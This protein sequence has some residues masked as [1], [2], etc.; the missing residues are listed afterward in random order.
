MHFDDDIHLAYSTNIH[1]GN[2][3]EE[4]FASLQNDTLRVMKKVGAGDADKPFGIGLRLSN[5]A[6]LELSDRERLT[7]FRHWLDANHGYVFTINGFPY[8]QFHGTRVKEQVYVPDW[9]SGERLEY[10]NRLFTLLA[11]LLPPGGEGSVSTLPGSFKPFITDPSQVGT[12]KR[13]L[14]ECARHI[15]SLSEAKG[16][17][18]H[19]GLEPEP[20]GYLETT[21]ETI[22]FFRDLSE[23]SPDPDMIRRRIGVN[24]DTCHMAI[25]FET[26][27]ASLARLAENRIRISK[28]HLSSALRVVPTEEV[29][30]GLGDFIDPVYLHQVVSRNSAGVMARWMDLDQALEAEPDQSGADSEWR[31]HFHVPLYA[32]PDG[33]MDTTIDHLEAALDYLSGRRDLCRHYEFE[34][35][36][37]EV[38]PARMRSD[39]VVDQ[40]VAE[41]EWCLKAFASRGIRWRAEN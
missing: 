5:Q 14:I 29:R 6:S 26:A 13:N 35:Y 41:Y 17:D 25:Q 16:L 24:Y 12:I 4:T 11:E 23:G 27:A 10:T 7:E 1:R 28:M 9:Q 34:T 37:W 33:G 32:R 21:P 8:G 31:I 39:S 15:E 22:D 30:R 36:T 38:L 3:W 40:L 19:L 2:S 18:L 20:F